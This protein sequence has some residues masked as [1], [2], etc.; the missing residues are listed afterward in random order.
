MS[1]VKLLLINEI[2]I[3][4][5]EAFKH[6]EV[7]LMFLYSIRDSIEGE[8][9]MA[10]TTRKYISMGA[11]VLSLVTKFLILAQRFDHLDPHLLNIENKNFLEACLVIK[12]FESVRS[13]S[14]LIS[15]LANI[16]IYRPFIQLT[17]CIS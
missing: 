4:P 12:Y 15:K 9:I 14:M 8:S 16:G 6:I 2:D 3:T 17:Y 13:K 7:F 1:T 11:K 10:T 5:C